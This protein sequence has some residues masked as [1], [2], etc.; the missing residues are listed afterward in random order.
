MLAPT[1]AGKV[2]SG[3]QKRIKKSVDILLQLSPPRWIENPITMRREIHTLSFVTLTIPAK[4]RHIEA[5]EG[6]KLLLAPWILK[7]RRKHNM[8]TYLWKAEFQRNGQLHYHITTP[9][10]LHYQYIK[11]EWNNLLSQNG[12]L[13]NWFK[14]HPTK[15]PN[16]T[17]VHKVYKID[18]I[19]AYLQKELCKSTQNKQ[20]SGKIWDCSMNLKK[21]KHFSTIEPSSLHITDKSATIK[22]CDKCSMLFHP[23]PSS[24]LPDITQAQYSKHIQTIREYK[25]ILPQPKTTK[26]KKQSNTKVKR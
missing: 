11:D 21:Y 18:C 5:N 25:E 9:T 22:I 2:T 16:S 3:N 19:Q 6:H 13:V 26:I 10:W 14:D 12:M 20:T 1:Y 15:M 4:E 17:D 24:L 23:N 7:M 8:S